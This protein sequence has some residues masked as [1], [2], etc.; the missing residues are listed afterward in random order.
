MPSILETLAQRY[1][2]SAAGRTGGGRDFLID[3]EDLLGIAGARDGDLRELAVAELERAAAESGGMLVIERHA[4]S[5]I[6]GNIRLSKDGGEAWLFSRIGLPSPVAE[7]VALSDFFMKSAECRVP[8]CYMERWRVWLSRLAD[9]ARSGGGVDPFRRGD[10][11][12]NSGLMEALAGVFNWQGESLL[13][14]A[15]AVIC[16]DSKRLKS[17]ENRLLRA[18]S[19]IVGEDVGLEHFGIVEKPREVWFHGPIEILLED[20][21]HCDFARLPGAVGLSERNLDAVAGVRVDAR[22]C[23]TV[24][25]EAVFL[26]LVKRNPGVLVIRAGYAGSAVRRLLGMLPADMDFLHFGDTDAAGFDILRYLRERC[27]RAFV[28]LMMEPDSTAGTPVLDD[29]EL[30]MLDRLINSETMKD[31]REALLRYRE[32]GVK[33]RF[34][35]E[36][37]PVE[38]V[39]D[40]LKMAMM[41]REDRLASGD[42]KN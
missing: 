37:V 25:N 34:E 15:S 14:F 38:R 13:P 23:L 24:E 19:S 1:T 29:R 21:G 8:D 18:I 20:G 41:E 40:R 12:G 35:Q 5:G 27:G 3:F 22:I 33:G 26:E 17:L 10:D 39:A 6:P 32:G 11:A 2:T 31:V 30:R 4:R 9:A 28:P 7:R 16:G 36:L 42:G